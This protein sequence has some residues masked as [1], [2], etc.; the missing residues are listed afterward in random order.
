ML[1]HRCVVV[2]FEEPSSDINFAVPST[3]TPACAIATD[4]KMLT[5]SDGS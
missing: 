2:R 5:P 4:T 3:V 1:N